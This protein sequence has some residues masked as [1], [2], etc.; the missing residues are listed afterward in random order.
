MILLLPNQCGGDEARVALM[1]AVAKKLVAD[2][3]KVL[4]EAGAGVRAGASDDAFA[5]AGASVVRPDEA[6]GQADIVVVIRPPEIGQVRAMKAGALLIG[7]LKPFDQSELVQAIAAAHVTALSLELLPRIT[8]AQAMDVLSSQANLAGYKAVILAAEKL[9][10]IFP[11]MMTAAGTL[12]PAK[13]FVIGAGVAGLQAI[14]TAKRL[15]A[16]V[17]AYDVR[18]T[19]KE[20]VQSVGGKFV[21]L[22]L[23]TAGAQDAGGYAREQSVEQQAKQRELMAKVIA[24]SDVVITTALVPG[25]PAPKLI[26][27]S[28]VERMQPGSVIVDLAAE[29]GG[30]CELTEPGETVVKHGVTIIGHTN[31]PSQVATH[32]SQMYAN[33]VH[34]LLALLIQKDGTLKLDT[35]D[36]IIAGTMLCQNGQVVHP[37]LNKQMN[38]AVKV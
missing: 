7:I 28:T 13:V 9:N 18:P 33:N 35:S 23:D 6:W 38:G 8:R 25:K 15:G 17:S 34:K 37:M 24:E 36:E 3:H 30:N 4:V 31:L 10:K 2:G 11:M 27:V 19:V 26:P 5:A 29:R 14:A 12:Q 32:A 21:E 16:V 20:Q 1:P 22:P